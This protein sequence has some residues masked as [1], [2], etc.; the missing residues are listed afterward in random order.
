MTQA[1]LIIL[2]ASISLLIAIPA[3]A[4]PIGESAGEI[5]VDGPADVQPGGDPNHPDAAV[6]NSGRSIF[7]WDGTPA[8]TRKEIFLR[9]FP[10]DGS[11]P[12]APVQVNTLVE[13]AQ[14][15]PR[16][17]VSGDGSFLVVW[18][19]AE[20]PEPE[21]NFVREV[22]RSQAFDAN[23]NP[24]GD[25]QL[26]STLAPLVA[27]GGI[28]ADVAA[29]R[30]GGYIAVWRSSQT[31]V[32][33]DS[34]WTIQARRIGSNGV[35]LAGQFQINSTMTSASENYPA[36]TELTDG[37]F[38]V[39]WTLPQVHG[40]RFAADGTPDGDDFQINTFTSG[41]ERETDLV[42]HE[43]G[44]VLVIWTDDGDSGGD[45]G[46]EIRGRLFSPELVAQGVDFR[47][48]TLVTGTQN[49]P[50]VADYGRGGFFVVWESTVSAGNDN[51]SQSIEGR[52]VTGSNQFAG[53]EFQVNNWITGDQQFPGIGGKNDRVAVG[54]HS[55][56][57]PDTSANVINGQFWSICG[58]FCDSFEGE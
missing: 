31:F 5:W 27:S 58:I 39:V 7:V 13:E 10:A 52:I 8:S 2:T 34:S 44:R 37:G 47:I 56:S 36:V 55:K 49:R 17:A 9:I 26:L 46:T 6:D 22:V 20:R 4:T 53:S 1:R 50:R 18:Q 29:L 3:L 45:D 32:S 42:L 48:N 21:N 54:W 23:A 28:Y 51:D 57:N 11:E 30:G 12:G 38:L 25:E 19:S 43:D 35:P 15:N 40:R 33:E 16:V 14:D 24:V 41:S